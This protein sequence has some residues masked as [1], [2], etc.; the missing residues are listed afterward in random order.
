[1]KRTGLGAGA[2]AVR[3]GG[4]GALEQS[5]EPLHPARAVLLE[6]QQLLVLER[7]A[8]VVLDRDAIE[9]H[10][11]GKLALDARLHEVTA[12]SPLGPSER[13]L[14]EEVRQAA[15]SNQLLLAHARS[16]VQGVLSLLAP[17]N[18]PGYSAPGQSANNSEPT[19]PPIALN[20]RR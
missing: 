16:C 20:V 2:P 19:P 5:A 1:M 18:M 15:L 7:A 4:Q 10:A 14:L 11:A 17:G 12:A 9:E 6:L 3:A 8:L 13:Q